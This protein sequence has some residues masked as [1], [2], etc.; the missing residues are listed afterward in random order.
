M[1][2]ANNFKNLVFIG[3]LKRREVTPWSLI[4]VRGRICFYVSDNFGTL[5][6]DG[7]KRMPRRPEEI[8]CNNSLSTSKTFQ[9]F[10]YCCY[11]AFWIHL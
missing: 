1:E 4:I 9:S 5:R 2:L 11:G 3:N 8:H 10:I 6:L 7:E